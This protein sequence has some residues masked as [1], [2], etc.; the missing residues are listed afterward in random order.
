MFLRA[1]SQELM[2]KL[3]MWLHVWQLPIAALFVAGW[4]LGGGWLLR[5]AARKSSSAKVRRI[6]L[7]RCCQLS[8]LSGTFG[9]GAAAVVL[10][11]FMGLSKLTGLPLMRVGLVLGAV[12]GVLVAWLVFFAALPVTARESLA[13]AAKPM[14]AVGALAVLLGAGAYFPALRDVGKNYH[15][16]KTVS[17]LVEICRALDAY[18]GD[19]GIMP[20]RL[21]QL[22]ENE[23]ISAD[24]LVSRI[25][26][27][28]PVG[29][30]YVSPGRKKANPPPMQ[31][32]V[33]S[34]ASKRY[35]DGRAALFIDGTLKWYRGHDAD[36]F[37]AED[38]NASFAAALRRVEAN[39]PPP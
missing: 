31:L 38:V 18:Y 3:R 14:A 2:V 16:H 20:D 13:L 19:Y 7:V 35:P 9:M 4:I 15:Y 5:T 29:Y 22:V 34:L 36:P 21:E 30:F 37:L 17:N 26:P 27:H 11:T 25:N 8:F 24:S 6:T 28:L 33:V 23:L 32:V 39:L 10:A 12:V 1:A